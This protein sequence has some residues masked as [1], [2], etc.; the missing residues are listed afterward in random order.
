MA[1]G[2]AAWVAEVAA[3]AGLASDGVV[4]ALACPALGMFWGWEDIGVEW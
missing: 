3:G 4:R 1:A 2:A